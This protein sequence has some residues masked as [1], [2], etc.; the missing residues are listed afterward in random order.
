MVYKNVVFSSQ[1]GDKIGE[2]D[3]LSLMIEEC[4]GLDKIE[5]LQA[6]ENEMVYKAALNLI[7]K[8]FSEAVR[9]PFKVLQAFKLT[10]CPSG[11]T[12]ISRFCSLRMRWWSLWPQKLPVTAMH[13]K[14]VKTR[15]LLI[16][17]CL[18]VFPTVL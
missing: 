15:A 2:S 3:K 16:S 4:G 10:V 17:K 8:Y 7:E 12:E 14:S 1:A 13:S 9:F 18:S 11:L 6:H 5:A